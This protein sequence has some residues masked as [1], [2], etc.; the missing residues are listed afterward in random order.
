MAIVGLTS[1][2]R[3][4]QEKESPMKLSWIPVVLSGLNYLSSKKA[5]K[6]A[7]KMRAQDQAAFEEQKEAFEAYKFTSPYEGIENPYSNLTNQFAGLDNQFSGLQNQYA[8]LGSQ[9]AGLQN[10]YEGLENQFTGIRNRFEDAQNVFEDL[11]VD[12]RAADFARESTQQ[13][14]ANLL[15][16]LQGVAGSSGV[17]SLAQAIAGAGVNQARQA[18][19]DIAQQERQ[20]Q[21]MARQEE[22]R[23]QQARLGEATRIDQLQ[24][25]EQARLEQLRAG[26]AGRL[27]QLQAQDRAR[28]QQLQ[29]GEAAR[30]QTLEAQEA[31]KLA[32]LTAQEQAKLD[33][34]IATGDFQVEMLDRKGQQYVQQMGFNRLQAM[35]GLSASNLS[36][37]TQFANQAQANANAAFSNFLTSA[38]SSGMFSGS[39]SPSISNLELANNS[40]LPTNTLDSSYMSPTYGSDPTFSNMNFG[41]QDYTVPTSNTGTVLDLSNNTNVTQGLYN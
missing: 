16:Q 32:Q 28:I 35:Y 41:P 10:Q 30:L 20:N 33:Q 12:T 1:P 17:A 18:S 26:E 38:V 22:A 34:L 23:L 21:L 25:Q 13:Q 36:A 40:T 29:A 8:G 4:R 2:F 6:K 14:Q 15:S 39:E 7:N 37:A 19:I 31:S 27:A 5:A 24:R 3:K 11:R 9:F